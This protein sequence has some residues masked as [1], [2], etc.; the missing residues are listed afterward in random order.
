[1]PRDIWSQWDS[2]PHVARD[3]LQPGDLVFFQN[4]YMEGLS[5]NGIYIGNGEFVNAVDEESG[6]AISKLSS[7]YWTEHWYGATRPR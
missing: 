5:H 2:G 1:M 3:Q 6:V 7:P 4:T